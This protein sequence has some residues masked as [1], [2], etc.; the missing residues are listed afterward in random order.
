MY[1]VCI[2]VVGASK[3]DGKELINIMLSAQVIL[4]QT[5]QCYSTTR[6]PLG[7]EAHVTSVVLEHRQALCRDVQ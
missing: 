4:T 3:N 7:N 6:A 5:N 1:T 2:Y